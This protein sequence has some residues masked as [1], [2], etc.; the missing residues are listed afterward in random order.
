[1]QCLNCGALVEEE[2]C[3]QCGQK[4]ATVRLSTSV[5]VKQFLESVLHIRKGFP[6]TVKQLILNPGK[7]I[8]GFVD[9]GRVNWYKPLAFVM[10]CGLVAGV[11]LQTT[12]VEFAQVS[13]EED[14]PKAVQEFSH[15][16]NQFM[17]KNYSL[18]TLAYIPIYALFSWLFFIRSGMNYAENLVLNG[19]THGLTTLIS[20]IPWVAVGWSDSD[21]AKGIWMG[22]YL[23][24]S[25]SYTMLSYVRFFGSRNKWL[26]AI[27]ALLAYACSIGLSML[28]AMI[29]GIIYFFAS[30]LLHGDSRFADQ[31]FVHLEQRSSTFLGPRDITIFIPSTYWENDTAHFPVI[32]M[33]DGSNLFDPDS[34]YFDVDMGLDEAMERRAKRDEPTAIVVGISNTDNRSWEYLPE[35]PMQRFMDEEGVSP[36]EARPGESFPDK[37]LLGDEYL[38]CIV[39]EIKPWMDKTFRTRPEREFTSIAGCSMG[40]LITWY[41]LCEYP[42]VFGQGA[43]ISTHWPGRKAEAENNPFPYFLGHLDTSLPAADSTRLWF[44]HGTEKLDSFYEP[45][46]KQVDSLMQAKGFGTSSWVSRTYAGEGHTANSWQKRVPEI[47]DFLLKD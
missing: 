19:Y 30:G 34:S 40:G 13:V 22:T 9:G 14:T 29:V 31:E 39:Q 8:R 42:D 35:E 36:Q 28:L 11:V 45:Y 6:Y 38:K 41:A 43:C 37:G 1:M 25:V 7:S 18:I 26:A 17:L 27:R 44:D 2:F 16:I 4:T 32:Y 3:G 33:H 10:L 47:L 46:Q 15:R 5:I 12:D 21:S 24:A 20:V 23:L